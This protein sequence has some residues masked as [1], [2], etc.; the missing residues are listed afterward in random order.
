MESKPEGEEL[1]YGPKEFFYND[2]SEITLNEVRYNEKE[3]IE[4]F[5]KL[6]EKFILIESEG[7]LKSFKKSNEEE[8]KE[9]KEETKQTRNLFAI[10]VYKSIPLKTFDVLGQK[11]SVRYEVGIN[12]LNAYNKIVISSGRGKFEFG[13]ST[14]S[15][16][17]KGKQKYRQP[18]FVFRPPP[19]PFV[20]VS[21]YVSGSLSF[22]IGRYSGS[23]PDTKYWIE[24]GGAL[25]LGAEIK[26]GFDAVFSV[27]AFAEGTVIEASGKLI[28]SK[29]NNFRSFGFKLSIGKLVVGVRLREFW[30][31]Q[32]SWST[33][34]FNGWT[35]VDINKP[36]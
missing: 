17:D 27:S 3:N 11:V 12:N 30:F 32:Q 36:F 15:D 23:G 33:T 8:E 31:F 28:L 16:N 26:L 1:T 10:N 14:K 9:D 35:L 7:L 5:N 19:F 34:L 22:G 2:K 20:A 25:S 6:A 13:M 21:C 24:L 29:G 18:V 4:L